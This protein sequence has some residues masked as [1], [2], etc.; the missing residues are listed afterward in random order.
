M[1]HKGRRRWGFNQR[2]VIGKQNNPMLERWRLTQTPL[3]GIYVHFI[4]RE[5][6]D[7]V[8]HDHPWRFWSLVLRGGYTEELHERPGSGSARLVSWH[9]WS[10]H[11]FPMHHA[12]RIIGV[13]PRTV[14]LV[15]VGRKRRVWGFYDRDRWIDYRDALGIRPTEGDPR[16]RPAGVQR[17]GSDKRSE[18]RE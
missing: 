3:F 6:L 1:S 2:F 10:V 12:H 15:V 14:T 5:D 8:P 17:P 16:K 4:H 9:R 11:H 7:R 18:T 13:A